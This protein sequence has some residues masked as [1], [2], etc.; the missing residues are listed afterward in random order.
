M[1]D[2]LTDHVDSLIAQAKDWATTNQPDAELYKVLAHNLL[3]ATLRAVTAEVGD[4]R[5][6]HHLWNTLLCTM[7]ERKYLHQ[8][9]IDAFFS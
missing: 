1:T 3:H 6:V 7:I 5:A 8:E 4:E 9:Q 2:T